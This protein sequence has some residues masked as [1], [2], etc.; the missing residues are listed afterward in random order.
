M[1]EA[2]CRKALVKGRKDAVEGRNGPLDHWDA[3]ED[4]SGLPERQD[5]VLDD[6]GGLPERRGV[7]EVPTDPSAGLS[8][9][10][11]DKGG[12]PSILGPAAERS[13]LPTDGEA[14]LPEL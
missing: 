1:K 14:C 13:R 11:G 3:S 5:A 6:R 9:V 12:L 4:S 2:F 8:R 10:W 7:E